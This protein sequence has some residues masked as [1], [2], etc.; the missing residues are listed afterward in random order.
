MCTN[1]QSNWLNTI[2]V[3]AS[4]ILPILKQFPRGKPRKTGGGGGLSLPGKKPKQKAVCFFSF[5]VDPEN[6][7]GFIKIVEMACSTTAWCSRGHTLECFP[8]VEF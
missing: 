4:Y 1:P 3:R 6:W 2:A 5:G 8:S 7:Q